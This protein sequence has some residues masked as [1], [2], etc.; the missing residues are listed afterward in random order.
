LHVKV[1]SDFIGSPVSAH[2]VLFVIIAADTNRSNF[3]KYGMKIMPSD[4]TLSSTI[5]TWLMCENVV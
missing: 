5:P 4:A 3:E 1:V 2:L